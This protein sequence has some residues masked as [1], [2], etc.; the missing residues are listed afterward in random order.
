MA[1]VL[2]FDSLL[3]LFM[4]STGIQNQIFITDVKKKL[5][6]CLVVTFSDAPLKR[7]DPISLTAAIRKLYFVLGL[8]LKK[9]I[10]CT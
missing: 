6:A 9:K 10:Y 4:M 8:K 1:F 7:L 3:Q 5:P 2:T